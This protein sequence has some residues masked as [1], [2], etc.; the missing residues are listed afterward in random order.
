[1]VPA[2]ATILRIMIHIEGKAKAWVDESQSYFDTFKAEVEKN[3][4]YYK[5]NQ[6]DVKKIY[7]NVSKAVENRMWMASEHT[8]AMATSRIPEIVTRSLDEA[9]ASQQEAYET[10][11]VLNYHMERL[12][13][14]AK[15]ERF[16][17]DMIVKRFGV[18][19][20]FWNKETD[21][22][23]CEWRDARRIRVPKF[24]VDLQTA[25]YVLEELEMSYEGIIDYFGEDIANKLLSLP[26][27]ENNQ[28]RPKN[29]KV[30]E[31]WTNDFV[32][33]IAGGEVL[34]KQK[35][36]YYDFNNKKNNFFTRPRKPFIIKSLFEIDEAIIGSTDYLQ[37]VL[38]HQ[39]AINKRK[40]QIEDIVE[41]VSNPY[42]LIDA[43]VMTEEQASNITNEPGAILYG[44]GVGDP[45]KVRFETPGQIQPAMF[46]DLE[47][48]RSEFD[49]IWGLHATT[50]GEREGK[51]TLGGR[52]LLKQG[53]AS[54]ISPIVRRLEAALDEVAEYWVQLISMFYTEEKSFSIM[55]DDGIKFV[56]KFTNEKVRKVIPM[57]KAGSTLPRDDVFMSELAIRLYQA[58]ALGIRT[59]YKMI[60]L[61]NAN[62]AIQ[63]YIE[64]QSGA[65]LKGGTPTGVPTEINPAIQPNTAGMKQVSQELNQQI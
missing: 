31:I 27:E 11:E 43:Q 50:R 54:R 7:G 14:Q 46:T 2:G 10:Q 61:P 8:I 22:V 62:A 28:V 65:L 35:N 24:G 29:F 1:M 49:D 47:V 4:D 12:D 17:R 9:E 42:M 6:T 40:R 56:S 45:N 37:Q 38:P 52:V 3:I 34:K 60:R 59:L 30:H 32:V 63:D 18:F 51:E 57:V 23:D 44:N 21:D 15:A 13:M 20:V 36:P 39:D 19:K 26:K 55:G 64:T 48:S 53:D 58:G 5:G 16:V 25:R 33:W 41:K